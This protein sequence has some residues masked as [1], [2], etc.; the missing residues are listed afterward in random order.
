MRILRSSLAIRNT[1]RCPGPCARSS[2]R[3]RRGSNTT[4]SAPA[5]S[6]APSAR[7]A[8]RRSS[9]PS[10][11][12]FGCRAPRSA[13]DSV[14]VRSVTRAVSAGIGAR[15]RARRLP[16]LARSPTLRTRSPSAAQRAPR[17]RGRA[18]GAQAGRQHARRSAR[19]R[20]RTRAAGPRRAQACAPVALLRRGRRR[21]RR[22][23]APARRLPA[24]DALP[25]STFGGALTAASSA[26]VKLGFTSI[27]NIIAVRLVG[28]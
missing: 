19:R 17:E 15:P 16:R 22:P 13:A 25:K 24:S 26:T 7:R 28:N 27:L 8:G 11:A 21:G 14:C 4:R 3:R 6:T 1:R 2:R 18:S 20:A 5:A 9:A 23:P 12:S 10:A